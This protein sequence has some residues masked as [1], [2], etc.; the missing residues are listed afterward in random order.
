M[1]DYQEIL[2]TIYNEL[3][4]IEDKGEV[5]NYIPELSKVD[6]S[7]FGIYLNRINEDNYGVGDVYTKF[8]VQ[9]ISK[10]FTLAMAFGNQG[11]KLWKRVDVEPS[12]NPFNHLAL[13][14]QEEGIP[15][16]PLIN[17]GAIVVADCLLSTYDNPKAELL[18]FVR[19]LANDDNID[20]NEK[21]AASEMKTGFT[22]FAIA[23][24]LKSFGNLENPVEEVLDFYFHQCSLEMT[25]AQIS[26][27][28]V[29]FANKGICMQ[30]NTCLTATQTKRINAIMLTCGFYDEAGE[31]AFEVGLPGKSGVGGGIVAVLPDNFIITTW[32]PGLNKKGNSYLGM[33]ALEKFTT[34]TKASI[35]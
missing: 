5:A 29:P 21:V 12:G 10:V 4:T 31:F 28:F 33:L 18:K 22:N 15:R 16:N 9:S 11:N 3:R 30:G 35:F 26:N 27:A 20:F 23:N 17:S 8:S 7:K 32:S 1:A 13:L 6:K 19:N 2:N 25:C 14:E 24:L 34:A